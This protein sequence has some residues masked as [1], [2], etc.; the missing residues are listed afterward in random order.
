MALRRAHSMDYKLERLMANMLEN[1]NVTMTG[2]LMEPMMV[3][4]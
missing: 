1:K 3:T 2:H 4:L